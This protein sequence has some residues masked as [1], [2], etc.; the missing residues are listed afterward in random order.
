MPR[1]Q[2]KRFAQNIWSDLMREVRSSSGRTITHALREVIDRQD[3][4]LAKAHQAKVDTEAQPAGPSSDGAKNKSTAVCRNYLA[5]MFDV[6][7]Y[8][9]L[10]VKRSYHV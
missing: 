1:K 5:G 4:W 6:S 9:T 3:F 10:N 7:C 8:V 2:R